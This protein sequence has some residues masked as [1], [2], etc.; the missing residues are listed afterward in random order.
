[1]AHR[2]TG[3]WAGKRSEVVDNFAALVFGES[4]KPPEYGRVF[5]TTASKKFLR[6]YTDY[7]REVKLSMFELLQKH[8]RASSMLFTDTIL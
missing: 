8:I 2:R 6:L 4:G 5:S 1:M 3:G 7:K